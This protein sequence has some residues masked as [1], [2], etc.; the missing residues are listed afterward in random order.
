MGGEVFSRR[1]C[2]VV[3]SKRLSLTKKGMSRFNPEFFFP[4]WGP[5]FLGY[6]TLLQHF[7]GRLWGWMYG[8]W[9]RVSLKIRFNIHNTA[10]LMV[11]YRSFFITSF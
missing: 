3:N 1:L 6:I 7:E 5:V 8:T 9:P 4:L 11:L 10:T 2:D